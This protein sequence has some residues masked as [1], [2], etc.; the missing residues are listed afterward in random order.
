MRDRSGDQHWN[1]KGGKPKCLDCGE[2]LHDYK[3]KRCILH[4]HINQRNSNNGMWKGESVGYVGLHYWIRRK[5]GKPILCKFEDRSCKGMLEW[6]NKDHLY[7]RDLGDWMSV[8]RS[9]HRRFDLRG[10]KL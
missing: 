7:K 5:L 9:H 6:A 3:S 2:L 1:W 4:G 8:C 10:F